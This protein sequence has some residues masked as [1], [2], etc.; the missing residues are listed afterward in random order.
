MTVANLVLFQQPV[1][2][3]KIYPALADFDRRDHDN[4]SGTALSEASCADGGCGFMDHLT[5][6][7]HATNRGFSRTL[8]RG[9][10]ASS[11]FALTMPS[12][13]MSAPE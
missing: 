10:H 2:D 4:T 1:T 6:C 7:Y 12:K 5:G 13:K 3:Q 11:R 9:F 8:Q